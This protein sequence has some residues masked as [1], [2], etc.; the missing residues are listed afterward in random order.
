M[1]RPNC[2]DQG[3]ETRDQAAEDGV[4]QR[5]NWRAVHRHGVSRHPAGA[6]AAFAIVVAA[7]VWTRVPSAPP[8]VAQLQGL[9][10]AGSVLRGLVRVEMNGSAPAESA[11]V[12]LVPRYPGAADTQYFGFIFAYDAWRR[13]AMRIYAQPLLGPILALLDAAPLGGG[14]EAAV[15]SVLR[16]DGTRVSQVVGVVRG[17]ARPLD[18]ATAAGVLAKIPPAPPGVTWR[19]RTHGGTTTDQ[20]RS[21]RVRPRQPVRLSP[22]GGGPTP[23]IIPDSR[24]DIVEQGYRARQ[25]GTYT[26]R[27]LLPS[28]PDAGVTLTILVETP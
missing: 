11:V 10:P 16:D 28:T 20:A 6:V 12:A 14:R 22:S 19:F 21:L 17:R 5:G 8:S 1:D 23:I 26:I 18:E 2:G 15:F 3:P 9:L 27:I 4:V 25:P 24:L 13:K 7:A